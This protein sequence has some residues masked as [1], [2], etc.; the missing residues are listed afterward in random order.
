ML[1]LDSAIRIGV[2]VRVKAQKCSWLRAIRNEHAAIKMKLTSGTAG[3]EKFGTPFARLP[4]PASEP[5]VVSENSSSSA[6]SACAFL[7]LLVAVDVEKRS[8]NVFIVA[9]DEVDL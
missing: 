2:V 4:N 7:K 5:H 1:D 9:Q 8:A 3:T 6:A